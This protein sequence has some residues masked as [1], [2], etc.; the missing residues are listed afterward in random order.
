MHLSRDQLATSTHTASAA[1]DEALIPE[2][3]GVRHGE[4]WGR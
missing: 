2:K 3:E 1:A 4:E